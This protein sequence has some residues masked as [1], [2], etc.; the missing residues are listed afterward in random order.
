MLEILNHIL[1]VIQKDLFAAFGLI[2]ILYLLV[3]LLL[4]KNAERILQNK[5]FCSFM[6][7][8]GMVYLCL[9][10]ILIVG[11]LMTH[12]EPDS[13]AI[14][15]RM[16]GKYWWSFW[17]Q[18]VLW[19][20]ATQLLRIPKFKYHPLLRL[21]ISLVLLV[22]VELVAFLWKVNDGGLLKI[23]LSEDLLAIGG[24]LFLKLGIFICFTQVYY[25][26]FKYVRR[27]RLQWREEAV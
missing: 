6:I 10:I 11:A 23:G 8:L 18:M 25:G 7:S 16:F 26:G 5:I 4:P 1:L 27:L 13:A 22:P 3:F 19:I 24:E 2:S 17:L 20:W 15:N 12:Q 21:M 14:L 9:W